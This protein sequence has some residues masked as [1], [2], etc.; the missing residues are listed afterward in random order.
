[1]DRRFF[2]FLASFPL[3]ETVCGAS[4]IVLLFC[5]YGFLPILWGV[6]LHSSCCFA[7]F[8]ASPPWGVV[9]RSSC[10]FSP[11]WLRPLSCG[12]GVALST[13]WLLR[14]LYDF[15]PILWLG[16][17]ALQLWLLCCLYS[18]VPH[19][20]GGV[21]RF[22]APTTFAAS[23]ASSPILWMVCGA[24]QLQLFPCLRG[25]SSHPIDGV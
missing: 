7:V 13:S 17:R 23:L 24:L 12:W 21:M 3:P 5:L 14:C 9:L 25:S 4:Q 2:A 1:M 10:C 16:H 18:F 6:A 22:A 19:S 8:M 15:A 20:M 11:F